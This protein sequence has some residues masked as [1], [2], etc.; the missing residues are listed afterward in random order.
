MEATAIQ[1]NINTESIVLISIYNPPGKIIE[2][3]LD[4]LIGTGHKVILAGDFNA[5]HVTWRARQNNAAGQSLLSHYY[6]NNYIIS[7]PS[8]PT[9]FPDRN[10]AGAEILDFAILSNVLSSHSVRT[11]SSLS[12]SD[13]S[14]VLLTIRGPLEPDEIKPNFIYREANWD[15]FQNYL[16]NNLNTQCLEG[17]CSKSEIDVAVRHLTD[18]L[19]R[20]SLFAIPLKRRTFRSMQI[21][22][23][24]RVLIQKRN[25]LRT[26]WQRTHDII[27]RPLINSL[28]EQIDSAIKEQL[29]NTWQKT[30]QGL[31]TNNMRDTWRLTNS[32][33]GTALYGIS[34]F[35]LKM[36]GMIYSETSLIE[37]ISN[38]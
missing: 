13:H 3:D 37:R 25:R 38:T 2:S 32:L 12:T 21:S 4:L 9:H 7:A 36:E 33:C 24:T 17:N 19:N 14:P 1:L 18:I 23:P 6:K 10:P 30:L 22:T 11:L 5:K 28:R 26:K 35:M 20:A 31:D 8:Q 27:L 15:L 16:V 34:S 29:S